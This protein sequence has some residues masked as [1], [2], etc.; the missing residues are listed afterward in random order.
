MII[1]LYLRFFRTEDD[2]K[3]KDMEGIS[4]FFVNFVESVGTS[5]LQ[6]R[7]DSVGFTD[8]ST[9]SSLQNAVLVQPSNFDG[10][11]S[12]EM[13]F[14]ILYLFQQFIYEH[15]SLKYFD[16]IENYVLESFAFEINALYS[17]ELTSFLINNCDYT[18]SDW[19]FFFEESTD[20]TLTFDHDALVE[21]E[22]DYVLSREEFKDWKAETDR[23]IDEEELRTFPKMKSKLIAE[24]E[25]ERKELQD[26]GYTDSVI[27]LYFNDLR[28]KPDWIYDD[29]IESLILIV[30]EDELPKSGPSFP[31]YDTCL[32][33]TSPS[34]RD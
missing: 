8:L 26:L 17:S 13:L 2:Y 28:R 5:F 25:I 31:D 6:N 14:G 10:I 4:D 23:E 29:V 33:Y 16:N 3:F 19:L 22:D 20:W 12:H 30:D 27:Q 1:P 11:I 24:D 32:L 15:S 34:P 18:W 7:P 9:Y 21:I